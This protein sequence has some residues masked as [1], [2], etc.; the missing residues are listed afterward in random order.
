MPVADVKVNFPVPTG[1]LNCNNT[2]IF[3]W[4]AVSQIRFLSFHFNEYVFYTIY[5]FN[6]HTW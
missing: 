3:F 6:F 2:G 5:S 1:M 4:S